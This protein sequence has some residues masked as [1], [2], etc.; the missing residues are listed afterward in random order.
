MM[1]VHK[2]SAGDGYTYY[3]RETASADVRRPADKELGD[4]YLES[5]NPPGVWMGGGIESLGMSGEV[6]EA[7][8]KALFGEGMHPD[9]DRM[10]ADRIAAGDSAKKAIRA[11]KLGRA[12]YRYN[13]VDTAFGRRL[14]EEMETFARLNHR[15][16]D[17][18]ERAQLR[19]KAGAVT[20]REEHGRGP[21][22]KEELGQ[23]I[24][25]QEQ[26]KTNQA[27]AGY[28]L[29][30]KPEPGINALW[31]LGDAGVQRAIEEEHLGAITDTL[32]WLEQHA[33]MTRTGVNGIAQEDI[34]GGLVA[35]RWR[36]YENRSGDAMLH[37]HVV[38]ANKV[39]GADGKWRSIDGTLLHHMAVA[40]SEHYN[41]RVL[42]R[43]CTRLGLRATA[44]EVTP[45]KR[46]VMS[47]AGIPEEL[48]QLQSTRGADIKRRTGEL[49]EEYRRTHRREPSAKKMY[50]IAKQAAQDG[51]PD[52]KKAEPL[53][54]LR[55]RW[56]DQA[57]E[58]LG[59]KR[60]DTL[61]HSAREAARKMQPGRAAAAHVDLDAA[62]RQVLDVVSEERSVWGR[63]QVLAEAQRWVTR[64]FKGAEPDRDLVDRI[65]DQVLTDGSVEI[66][67]PDPNPQFAPLQR[68]DGTSVY[69]HRETELY[70]STEVLAAEDR[71]VAAARTS[72]IPAVTRETYEHV[73]DA[74]QQAHPDR[75]L[76]AGQRAMAR[77]FATSERLVEVAIGPAGAGKT[78][79]M[80]VAADA[81][82]ASGGRVIGLGPS[83]RA[84]A[85]LSD[86]IDAPAYTL[87]EWLGARE[88]FRAG[89][90]TAPEF[91]LN[92]GDVIVV[93]EA[94]MA[95]TRRLA[96]VVDEA[97]T[98]GAVVRLVGDPY[99]LAAVEAGGALRL[100]A[101]EV[102]AVELEA[103]HRFA[104]P[105]EAAASLVLRNGE[106]EHAWDWYL[107][108]HRIVAGDREEMLHQIFADWQ[109]DQTEGR[110]AMMMADDNDTVAQLN[111]RAQAWRAGNGELD[112]SRRVALR[113]GLQ[114]HPGDLV[115]TRRNARKNT[116]HR[117]RD[118]VKNGDQWQVL[119]VRRNGDLV[120]KHTAHR[121][122]TTLPAAYVERYV[123]MGYASTG[124]RGQGATVD[125]G[126]GLFTRSTTREAAYV[127]TTRGRL[128]NRIY[129]VLEKGERMRDVLAAIAR[130]TQASLSARETIRAEQN[131]AW[132]IGTLAA[133]YTDVHDRATSLR[134]QN[135]ARTM[136]GQHA[137]HLLAEDAWPAVVRALRDIERAGFAPEKLL[138]DAYHQR[139]FGDAEDAA[140]VLS[141]RLD[142]RRTE[143]EETQNRLAQH[144]PA[145]PLAD[146]TDAQLQ[147][148]AD[149]AA[150][151]RSAALD[152]LRRAD[153]RLAG[154][155]QPVT[156]DGEVHSAW[157]H[158]TFGDLTR[159]QL[160]DAIAQ[161]R[162]DGRI[163]GIEGNRDTAREAAEDL[164]ALRSEQVLRASMSRL[165]RAREDW[166]RE[167]G[168][169]RAHT[170]RQPVEAT[171]KEML[172]APHEQ[173]QA[174]LQLQRA[175][176]IHQRVS[177]EQRLRTVLPQ[178]VAAVPEHGETVPQWLAPRDV[179]R[180]AHT[181]T[182][183]RSHLSQ[184]RQVLA[185][186]LAQTGRDLAA[187]P[188]SWTRPLGPVPAPDTDL[189]QT[190][191][192]TAA[193]ADAWRTRHQIRPGETGLGPRP[194]GQQDAAA[195]DDLHEQIAATGRRTRATEAAAVRGAALTERQPE[196]EP[197]DGR[198]EDR[199]EARSRAMADLRARL[200]R[201]RGDRGE[202]A[203]TGPQ[204]P[205]PRQPGGR[206]DEHQAAARRT[207]EERERHQRDERGRGGPAR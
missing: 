57:V 146:L 78:T 187:D 199:H 148:L 26:A 115:V 141:W 3:V 1:T 202:P 49:V 207:R 45:G 120:V 162:R 114:A 101:N 97:A 15:E 188:P 94:G 197:E 126:S 182:P 131:R 53:T 123:E 58:T 35:T 171:R 177:A 116:L 66:T 68:A 84:A 11:A 143:A 18:A 173:R 98:A 172:T 6:T 90:R 24:S 169:G 4:Y 152:T 185:E 93:D 86:G 88:R 139:D 153:A 44:R 163:A 103:V 72:V 30:F 95:G 184:R 128:T 82:R 122:R 181:P 194:N 20:F 175:E 147:R 56:R 130:N 118:F 121:G 117:G 145:R 125:T 60:V 159:R 176:V 137:E 110:S 16:P 156:A 180:D 136:L 28:D 160:S 34:V 87:H 102:G 134:Y 89:R 70:T 201:G 190:W 100:L 21:A 99:Q 75:P 41:A 65:T 54:V 23:W 25:N 205:T 92:P 27:V 112:M 67:P 111:A 46:P 29:V 113:D 12:Y 142:V 104:D 5:G 124:H 81:V 158:R 135:L 76:D 119:K 52:K 195:W 157:P 47:I 161:A 38:V 189:R 32:Q 83:A 144:P 200:S 36:H 149:R 170:S 79:S 8:M 85:E 186:R 13:Q 39:K 192:R 42:E 132:N 105:Q 109:Q 50:A 69:R 74:Y 43:T 165:Q 168:T 61:L 108:Q 37:D 154:Q 10:V 191:E 77:T 55:A 59:R 138:T 73:E 51:R 14:A 107:A 91:Q 193:L 64:T 151:R 22:S 80:R 129:L 167:P 155:P 62:A 166:Q 2:L 203:Q 206:E 19:G 63:R 183:W 150:T 178:P 31:S 40:A 48:I 133:Q 179:E 71:I 7:Q 140:A 196:R 164:H 9:R 106:T 174:E 96:R 204:R 17:A 33:V 198:F 127:Q